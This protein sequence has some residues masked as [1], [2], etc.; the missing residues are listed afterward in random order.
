MLPQILSQQLFT[1]WYVPTYRS[2][3]NRCRTM[4]LFQGAYLMDSGWSFFHSCGL[5]PHINH[6]ARQVNRYASSQIIATENTTEKAPNWWLD[7]REFPE[8]FREIH[9][10]WT[11][12]A[13]W[14]EEPWHRH[15]AFPDNLARHHLK[16]LY[17]VALGKVRSFL[18][19]S[20]FGGWFGMVS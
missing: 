3:R 18:V 15:F 12:L 6:C 20:F 10:W 5:K 17:V 8:N 16:G 2:Y 1:I 19:S 7:G 11:I 14:M 13:R 9:F 4:A